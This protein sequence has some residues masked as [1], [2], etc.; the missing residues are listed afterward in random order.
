M[1]DISREWHRIMDG[2]ESTPEYYTVRVR[3]QDVLL[4]GIYLLGVLVGLSISRRS[5]WP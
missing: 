2:F 1:T 3:K 5:T 4:W